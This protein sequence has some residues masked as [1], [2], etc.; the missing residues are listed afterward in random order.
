M[1]L[2]IRR[3]VRVARSRALRL[4]RGCASLLRARGIG[5]SAAARLLRDVRASAGVCSTKKAAHPQSPQSQGGP[6]PPAGRA[7]PPSL[8]R[9]WRPAAQP[10]LRRRM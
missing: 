5:M 7:S 10:V 3:R 4:R 9:P 8:P 6:R 1:H 2:S